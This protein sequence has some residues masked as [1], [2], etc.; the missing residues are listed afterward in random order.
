MKWTDELDG[1]FNGNPCKIRVGYSESAI[2]KLTKMVLNIN[3]NNTVDFD[4][5]GDVCTGSGYLVQ[6]KDL[7][8]EIIGGDY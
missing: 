7:A 6:M 8:R 4:I 2:L 3:E 5:S 1:E